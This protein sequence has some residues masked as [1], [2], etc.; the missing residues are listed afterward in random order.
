MRRRGL[1][2]SA[3]LAALLAAGA[4]RAS[5]ES[6]VYLAQ[7][8][9]NERILVYYAT[10]GTTL[11]EESG[12]AGIGEVVTFGPFVTEPAVSASELTTAPIVFSIFLAT[13]A[14]PMT[15]CARVTL[16]LVKIPNAGGAQVIGSAESVV[17][18]VPKTDVTTPVTGTGALDPDVGLRT[19][20]VGDKLALTI[21]VANQC[22]DGSHAV[23]LYYGTSDRSSRLTFTD[24]CPDVPNPDQTDTDGD[25]VGDA[26][27]LCPTV[28]SV[29]QGDAD[30]DGIG[31]ACDVCP[32]VADPAQ[33]DS[34][35]DGVGD[36]CD[37]C[38]TIAGVDGNAC[39]C[40]ALD[41]DD[42]DVCTIDSCVDTTGCRNDPFVALDLVACRIPFLRDTLVSDPGV[43]QRVKAGKSPVRR[44]LKQAGRV[45]LRA[46]RAHRVGA[47][48]YPRRA[49]D[50]AR[51]LERFVGR[52][53][54]AAGAGKVP[55][56]LADR[57][58]QLTVQ[59][60]AAIPA[61]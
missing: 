59:A 6:S 7:N 31:D 52:L 24:N 39:T 33:T 60:V 17:T 54:D 48:S 20:D 28:A 11:E 14:T 49:A 61:S 29:E 34:D 46:E 47:A 15:D 2:A 30:G 43:D 5:D 40:V 27:D 45:F 8:A 10:T 35:G 1:V 44:A 25:G 57:L 23:R 53:H 55:S 42:G 37:P 4:A 51:R 13:G 26:C 56:A 58:S 50:L 41:C 22:T 12:S 3:T 9:S 38:P 21:D 36:A 32:T 18:L 16:T 19:L